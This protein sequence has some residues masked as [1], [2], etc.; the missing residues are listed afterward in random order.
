MSVALLRLHGDQ[1]VLSDSLL[2]VKILCRVGKMQDGNVDTSQSKGNPFV[3]TCGPCG[4]SPPVL[5][6]TTEAD[7]HAYG[8][9]TP[10][11]GWAAW[12]QVRWRQYPLRTGHH[13]PASPQPLSYAAR[14]AEDLQ[15]GL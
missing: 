4:P 7:V 10:L 3:L 5:R 9:L 6:A 2:S 14:S 1:R 15:L 11:G 8:R 12:C 13:K